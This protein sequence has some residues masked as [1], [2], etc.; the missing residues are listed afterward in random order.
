MR[1]LEHIASWAE[2][3]FAFVIMVASGLVLAGC[4]GGGSITPGP[5]ASEVAAP[6]GAPAARKVASAAAV[7]VGLIL[8]LS[9]GGQTAL[10]AKAMKQAGE[11]ALFEFDNPN[12]QLIV[13]DGKGTPEGASAAAREIV[14]AGAELVLGPLYAQSVT[15]AAAVARPAGIPM[16][17]FSN[18]NRVAGNGTFLLSFPVE[19]EVQRIVNFAASRGK[20]RFAALIPE[21]GYG[22][23]VQSAFSAAVQRIGGTVAI[24]ERVP[25]EANAML[26]PTK[27]VK[28]AVVQAAGS[29]LPVDA[30]FIPA[31]ETMLP[32]IASLLRYTD[33]RRQGI[34]LLGVGGWDYA[35]V[36]RET[37]LIGGWYTGPDPRGWRDFSQ[38]FAKAYGGLPPRV[39]SFVFDAVSLAVTLAGQPRGARFTAANLTRASGF[40]GV[41]GLFRFH[42]NGRVERGYAILEV[43]K[44]ATSTI[45]AA[46]SR[47]TRSQYVT[48]SPGFAQN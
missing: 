48:S 24:V 34:Q 14:N 27:A 35:N 8:P 22:D 32:T 37:A 23:L 43:Q 28:A 15:A 25:T 9:A 47:F 40:S 4:A 26:Q 17:A 46:P 39:A 33:M 45:D 41:D 6:V 38:R 10:V 11:L 1:P 12:V 20:R 31:D 5:Q 30:L 2:R 29:G 21:G 19:G 3:A 42:S 44:F 18:D 13:R 7:K 36:G 16:I